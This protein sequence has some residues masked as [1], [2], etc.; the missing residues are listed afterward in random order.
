MF[1]Y[2]IHMLSLFANPFS[3]G[4]GLLPAAQVYVYQPALIDLPIYACDES[5]WSGS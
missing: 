3:S 5:K 2:A 1:W 4:P